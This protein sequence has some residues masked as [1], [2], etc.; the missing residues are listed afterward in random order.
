MAAPSYAQAMREANYHP[1]YHI[2]TRHYA[3]P[4]PSEGEASSI[5]DIV[6]VVN[7]SDT[8]D[9][10]SI[11]SSTRGKRGF[12][13]ALKS[14]VSS[15]RAGRAYGRPPLS[16]VPSPSIVSVQ[17]GDMDDSESELSRAPSMYSLSR[18]SFSSRLGQLTSIPLPTASSLSAK[19][20]SQ[21]TAHLTARCISEAGEQIKIWTTKASDVLSDLDAQ[22]DVEWSSAGGHDGVEEVE[23]AIG[24]FEGLV[25]VYVISI[26]ELQLRSDVRTLS[27]QT[28]KTHVDQMEDIVMRWAAIKRTLKGVKEQVEIALEWE[29]L[30]NIAIGEIAQELTALSE[31]I[32]EM[33]EDRHQTVSGASSQS[34][35]IDLD[36]LTVMVEG[37]TAT[38]RTPIKP[39]MPESLRFS[40]GSPIEFSSSPG[41]QDDSKLLGLF[42]RM[43][44]VRASLDFLPMR[45]ST[46]HTKAS[47]MFPTGCIELEGRRDQLESQWKKIE[48]DA[49]GL[50][51][52]LGE[53][54]WLTV[55][56][57]AGN[58]A[59]KMFDSVERSQSKIKQGILAGHYQ[60]A[61][62]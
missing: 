13:S 22:D 34:R 16:P 46:F 57:N 55:F 23:Q 61:P 31:L 48:T 32:F 45:L 30:W 15:S 29:E 40:P 19:I 44:P 28:L 49:E 11:A 7:F 25:K 41:R 36:E 4:P 21:S 18:I 20:S 58:Q 53:D 51:K 26:E 12:G 50:K 60:T 9:N 42:A 54:R 14:K 62:A 52:E 2:P 33:E 47:A 5:P 10:E 3:A 56:R 24:R 6:S 39:N 38:R 43:Q 59:L 1:N 17:H 37:K 35:S 8:D 27:D